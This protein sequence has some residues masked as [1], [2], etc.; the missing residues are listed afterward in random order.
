MQLH[1]HRIPP[2]L[3]L[4][5][6]RQQKPPLEITIRMHNRVQL[7]RPPRS[8]LLHPLNIPLIHMFENTVTSN[9]KP[10]LL[11]ILLNPPQHVAVIDA[12]GLQE[13]REVVDAKMSIGAAVRFAGAGGVFG[14]DFLAG[15][16]GVAAA[17][18]DSVA[19]DVAVGVADVIAV[20]FVE[21]VV[22]Y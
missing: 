15:K 18:A 17:S 1:F 9:M 4:S 21:G 10:L 13:R 6:R 8:I 14:E 2:T 11:Y 3:R 22:G 5:P 19:A 20:F 7:R 12:G 16:G